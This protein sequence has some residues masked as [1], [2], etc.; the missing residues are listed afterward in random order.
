VTGS[1]PPWNTRLA[2]VAIQSL[3]VPCFY[4]P[5]QLAVDRTGYRRE[6]ILFVA[7]AGWDTAGARWFRYPTFWI[8]VCRR[9]SKS[10]KWLRMPAIQRSEA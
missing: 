10:S 7:S 4:W 1:V 6:E 5:A 9:L 3:G 8:I 2:H